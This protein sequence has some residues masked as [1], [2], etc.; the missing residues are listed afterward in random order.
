MVGFGVKVG[1]GNAFKQLE[2]TEFLFSIYK[3][4]YILISASSAQRMSVVHGKHIK[5]KNRWKN[6]KHFQHSKRIDLGSY[7]Y[8]NVRISTLV[9]ATH[10]R[11]QTVE[12]LNENAHVLQ[13]FRYSC[14]LMPSLRSMIISDCY[15]RIDEEEQRRGSLWYIKDFYRFI[16]F[17]PNMVTMLTGTGL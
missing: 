4:F 11:K 7:A 17:S 16:D 3:Q 12:Q 8:D 2:V 9:T 1:M 6:V 15:R 10:S 14:L 5:I 13:T